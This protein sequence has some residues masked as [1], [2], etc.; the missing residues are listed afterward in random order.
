MLRGAWCA[1]PKNYWK[2]ETY[3]RLR[4]PDQQTDG[5]LRLINALGV[6]MR[7]HSVTV[8]G[9]AVTVLGWAWLGF[10]VGVDADVLGS[11]S[12]V[13]L[14]LIALAEQMCLLGYVLVLTG[15][16]IDGF[17]RLAGRASPTEHALPIATDVVSTAT[18]DPVDADELKRR[19]NAL[20]SKLKA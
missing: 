16:V 17:D 6:E 2:V 13:N 18:A 8:V 10:G 15:V 20:G 12:V 4:L 19:L 11:R 14:H 5:S 3:P 9:A 7:I 1:G